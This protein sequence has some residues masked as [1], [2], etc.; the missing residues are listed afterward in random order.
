MAVGRVSL[1]RAGLAALRIHVWTRGGGRCEACQT[2]PMQELEH[3]LPRSRGGAD[4]AENCWGT[5]IPCHRLKEAPFTAGR[6]IVTPLGGERFRMERV[7]GPDK[8]TIARREL[9]RAS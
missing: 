9:L 5:C 3:A 7:W 6:L 1:S 2:R 8:W 4:S